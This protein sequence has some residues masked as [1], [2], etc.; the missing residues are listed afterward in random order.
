MLLEWQPARAPIYSVCKGRPGTDR[1]G[2][3]EVAGRG[4]GAGSRRGRAGDMVVLVLTGVG[5]GD[6]EGKPGQ[7]GLLQITAILHNPSRKWHSFSLL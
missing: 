7:G 1:D 4:W 5:S 2:P 6:S 3:W